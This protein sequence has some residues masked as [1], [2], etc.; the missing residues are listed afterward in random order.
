[1]ALLEEPNFFEHGITGGQTRAYSVHET[2][3]MQCD[4]KKETSTEESR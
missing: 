1:M 2:T 3:K 4:F